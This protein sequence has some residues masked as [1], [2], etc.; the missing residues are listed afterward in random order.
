MKV[1]HFSTAMTWRG[2]EQQVVYLYQGL[3]PTQIEQLLIC[4]EGSALTEFCANNNITF[5]TFKK[6]GNIF[7]TLKNIAQIIKEE[8]PSL[9]HAHDGKAHTLVYV[10]NVL[11]A[12]PL[13]VIVHRRVAF[14]KKNTF[15]SRLKY[16]HKSIKAVVCVSEYIAVINRALVKSKEKIKVVYDAVDLGKFEK[17]DTDFLR[18]ELHID[19]GAF[20]VG[21][22]AAF[23][24]EKDHLT[25]VKTAFKL[26]KSIPEAKFVLIG[27]GPLKKGTE[28]LIQE[29]GLTGNFILTGFLPESHKYLAGFDVLLFPSTIEG[30]GTTI[31]DAFACNVPVVATRTGG[32]P[33]IVIHEETGLLAAVGNSDQM[34]ESIVRLHASAELRKKVT[35]GAAKLVAGF[36][37]AK[38]TESILDVYTGSGS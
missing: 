15:F 37:I 11:S 20:V 7:V 14:A 4:P 24:A 38:M 35:E 31:L 28:L 23:T 25:F 19:R 33:E 17:T 30:L 16:N 18:K 13:P 27:D 8:K 6:S 3:Q 9:L 1:L 22:I 26:L 21:N 36:G 32:I 29:K 34:A 10:N 5:R 12:K 2:G